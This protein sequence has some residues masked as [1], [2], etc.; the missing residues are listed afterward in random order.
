MGCAFQQGSRVS[1]VRLALNFHPA[2]RAPLAALG[3]LL[4]LQGAH[5]ETVPA[6]VGSERALY[7]ANLP[8]AST[9]H[10]QLR[11]GG[12]TGEGE[13]RWAPEGGR[14]ELSLEGGVL[15]LKLLQ[16]VSSGTLD[17]HGLAPQVFSDRRVRGPAQTATFQ[18][19]KGTIRYSGLAEEMKWVAGAQDRL[20]WMLQLPA[21]LRA[22]P[23]RQAT[24]QVVEFYVSGARGDADVWSFRCVGM[25][26]VRTQA[27]VVPAVK[28]MRQPRKPH[29]SIVEVWLDPARQLWP[30]RARLGASGEAE[31]LELTLQHLTP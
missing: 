26:D 13:L 4:A 27:G 25:E 10:Y 5:S 31:S 1:I 17:A 28:W 14:Y 7:R 23:Q 2:W 24:G 21:V 18:R 12:L 11:K 8:A 20:S 19:D 15:G 29:D 30:V 22:E 9:L 16:Q 3:L 6:A